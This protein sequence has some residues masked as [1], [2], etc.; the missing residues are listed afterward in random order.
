MPG[1]LR[2][3]TQGQLRQVTQGQL[4]QVTQG[5]LRQVMQGQLRQVMQG[6]LQATALHSMLT[7]IIHK[8]VIKED[9]VMSEIATTRQTAPSSVTTREKWR[10]R[11]SYGVMM[12]LLLALSL[13]IVVGISLYQEIENPGVYRSEDE[14]INGGKRF[15]DY[16]YSL[17]AATVGREQFRALNMMMQEEDR[18]TRME[19]LVTTDFV[20]NVEDAR[21]KTEIQWRDAESTIIERHDNGWLEIEYKAYLLRDNY[22]AGQLDIVLLLVPTEKTDTNTDGVGVW[23]WKDIAENPFEVEEN[24]D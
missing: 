9:M 10:E 8:W 2:Q 6:Q 12:V 19:Y 17:N 20:R 14:M 3:V 22:P 15:I 11:I 4:R 23:A 18:N 13:S 7:M 16:F 5:Q 1:Q 24:E 21:M